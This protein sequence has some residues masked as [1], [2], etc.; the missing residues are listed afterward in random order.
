MVD[1]NAESKHP[2]SRVEIK[3]NV[4]STTKRLTNSSI[5]CSNLLF[6]SPAEDL[7]EPDGLAVKQQC[8]LSVTLDWLTKTLFFNFKQ[9]CPSSMRQKT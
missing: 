2:D 6:H 5:I 8:L 4:F 9:W 7:F 3:I 1:P